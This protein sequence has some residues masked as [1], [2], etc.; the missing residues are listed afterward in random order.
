MEYEDQTR[1]ELGHDDPY[2]EHGD[3]LD[4][5]ALG[6]GFDDPYAD[7]ELDSEAGGGRDY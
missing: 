6:D 4:E 7:D 1:D 2:G 5:D 3:D